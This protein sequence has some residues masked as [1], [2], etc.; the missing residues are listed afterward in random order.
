MYGIIYEALNT[1]NNKRYIGQTTQKFNH[2]ISDHKYLH[3]RKTTAFY[4]ALS[5]YGWDNFEWKIIDKASTKE[6]LDSKETFW[7]LHYNTYKHGGYNMT[8]GGQFEKEDAIRKHSLLEK[9]NLYGSKKIV[10]YDINGNYIRTVFSQTVFAKE[11]NAKIS[12]V[13]RCLHGFKNSVSGYILFFEDEFSQEK[14]ERR[15][16]QTRNNLEFSIFDVKSEKCIGVLNNLTICTED[17]N[18][19][20]RAMEKQLSVGVKTTPRKFIIKY[21][22]DCSQDELELIKNILK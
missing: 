16:K 1:I 9:T 18:F 7:I 4:M 22:S 6:D 14:L 11:I 8:M 15:I 17:T 12:N 3:K 20:R 5:K 2:R 19:S 10:V 13:N 21:L